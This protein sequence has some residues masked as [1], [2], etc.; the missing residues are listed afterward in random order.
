MLFKEYHEWRKD[1][2]NM[3]SLGDEDSQENFSI[4]YQYYRQGDGF[5]VM[6]A[7][8]AYQIV[9]LQAVVEGLLEDLEV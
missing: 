8:L 2:N 9:M 1:P 4:F 6:M 7:D 5:V 3:S